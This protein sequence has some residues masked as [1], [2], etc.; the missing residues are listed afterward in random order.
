MFVYTWNIDRDGFTNYSTLKLFNDHQGKPL[1]LKV[2]P[3]LSSFHENLG[4]VR[5]YIA[6]LLD[7]AAAEIPRIA[8]KRTPVFVLATAGMRLIPQ[9]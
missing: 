6:K 2:T 7:V 5:S 9:K 1:V 4:G 8:H 3:G